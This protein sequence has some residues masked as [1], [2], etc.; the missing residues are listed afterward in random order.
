MMKEGR[1]DLAVDKGFMCAHNK[2][3]V[4]VDGKTV[5]VLTQEECLELAKL[6]QETVSR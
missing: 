3:N 6:L 1:K 2:Y 4:R 5:A